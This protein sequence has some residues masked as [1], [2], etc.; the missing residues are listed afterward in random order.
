MMSIFLILFVASLVGLASPETSNDLFP[1]NEFF[2]IKTSDNLNQLHSSFLC[3]HGDDQNSPCCSCRD[4]CLALGSCCID[5]LWGELGKKETLD[6]Y[7]KRYVEEFDKHDQG[8]QCL[9]LLP[10]PAMSFFLMN[11]TDES[12]EIESYYMIN[13]CKSNNTSSEKQSL[14]TEK[15]EKPRF[16]STREFLPVVGRSGSLYRNEYCS[17]CNGEDNSTI[18][19]IEVRCFNTFNE[20]SPSFKDCSF[21]FSDSKHLKGK[22]GCF[23][24]SYNYS[25]D[26]QKDEWLHK[27]CRSYRGI[28]GSEKKFPNLHCQQCAAFIPRVQPS[29]YLTTGLGCAEISKTLFA[30]SVF[31]DYSGTIKY[32]ITKGEQTRYFEKQC[33]SNHSYDLFSKTCV[34]NWIKRKMRESPVQNR[35]ASSKFDNL[36]E[37]H[38]AITQ[39]GTST[40]VVASTVVVLVYSL[41]TELTNIH[42]LNIISM[43]S[44]LAMTDTIFLLLANNIIGR[45]LLSCC[46][47]SMVLYFGMILSQTW[48][49]I[50]CIDLALI[51]HSQ[52]VAVTRNKLKTF[53]RYLMSALFVALLLVAIVTALNE[54]NII[55]LINFETYCDLTQFMTQPW[56]TIFPMLSLNLFSAIILMKTVA[57]IYLEK[58]ATSDRFSDS[59]SRYDVNIVGIAV[60]LVVGLGLIELVGFVQTRSLVDSVF[61]RISIFIYDIA[62]SLRGTFVFAVFVCNKKVIVLLKNKLVTMCEK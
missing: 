49:L 39:Y 18:P 27:A 19:Q 59:G 8:Y 16:R 2:N 20:E 22:F 13:K 6:T 48:C 62:R 12:T 26:C 51:V 35:S 21:R 46:I 17:R 31:I 41:L 34:T 42:G 3:K 56:V 10:L 1:F 30:W 52:T 57:R 24:T 4:D 32:D 33:R 11:E 23:K 47:S 28:I 25:S 60:K 40:S 36:K 29:Q 9:K 37:I 61:N 50:I 55:Q 44:T 14:L 43:G 53:S 45:N 38:L 54:S 7:I 5:K 58:K 15:C